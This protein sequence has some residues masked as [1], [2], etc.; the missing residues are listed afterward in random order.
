MDRKA[1][2]V[3]ERVQSDLQLSRM[4][5]WMR[6][7]TVVRETKAEG[8]ASRSVAS[9]AATSASSLPAVPMCAGVQM[10]R[11]ARCGRWRCASRTTTSYRMARYWPERGVVE[12][13]PRRA[14]CESATHRMFAEPSCSAFVVA[15][16]KPSISPSHTWLLPSGTTILS[17]STPSTTRTAAPPA[18]PSRTTSRA[19]RASS[20]WRITVVT[21]RLSLHGAAYT[22]RIGSIPREL[23][24][25]AAAS[26]RAP[27][28]RATPRARAR[29][30]RAGTVAGHFVPG[31]RSTK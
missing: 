28:T 20:F 13:I 3:F 15:W 8:S 27:T 9:L 12:V 7:R 18:L 25:G 30:P 10:L 23:S 29:C 19:F 1:A 31:M 2:P 22:G 6:R 24:K 26:S 11:M 14:A 21:G 4:D 5:R 16:T 17:R